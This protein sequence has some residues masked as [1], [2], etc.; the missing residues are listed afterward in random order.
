M[1][2]HVIEKHN[3]DN[4]CLGLFFHKLAKFPEVLIKFMQ[5][6]LIQ[7]KTCSS[8]ALL[9]ILFRVKTLLKTGI[10]ALHYLLPMCIKCSMI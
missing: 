10:T 9:R 5:P 6:I 8:A 7:T 4:A 3:D 2:S 1:L